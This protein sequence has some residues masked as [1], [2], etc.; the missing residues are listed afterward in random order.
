MDSFVFNWPLWL[1][2]T[3]DSVER[4]ERDTLVGL[5]ESP[6][7]DIAKQGDQARL[8][9]FTDED[10]ADRYLSRVTAKWV[11][12]S[13]NDPDQFVSWLRS[14]AKAGVTSLLFDPEPCG[15]SYS[16]GTVI[17]SIERG[18]CDK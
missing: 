7:F 4:D 18:P 10:L 5:K 9:V 2:T 14:F 6:A 15:I 12:V 16:I 11:K 8:I 17:E 13:F 1:L 3:E